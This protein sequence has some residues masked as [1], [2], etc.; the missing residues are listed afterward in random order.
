MMLLRQFGLV[1]TGLLLTSTCYATGPRVSPSLISSASDIYTIKL[2]PFIGSDVKQSSYL[3]EVVNTVI[4]Q[5]KIDA[6]LT[7]LPLQSMVKYYLLQDNALA[8]LSPY[9]HLTASQKKDKVIIPMDEV[10]ESYIYYKLAHPNGLAWKGNL[11]NLK[12]LRYGVL[13]GVATEKYK[14][15]GISVKTARIDALLKKLVAKE[16]DFVRLPDL[17]ADWLIKKQF[18]EQKNNFGKMQ[19]S[20]GKM[21]LAIIFNK[22]HLKGKESAEM[23][24]KGFDALVKKG[25]FNEIKNEFLNVH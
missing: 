20:A 17:T 11:K 6:I 4:R 23:F 14:K 19:V 18:P 15:S 10:N 12:G 22:K 13:K 2:P 25:Q 16:V 21:Q 9:L 7:I 8:V 3:S 1:I 5:Q 24:K